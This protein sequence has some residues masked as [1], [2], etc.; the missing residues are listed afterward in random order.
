MKRIGLYLSTLM[1]GVMLSAG[2]T[3]AV[4]VTA[5]P[6]PLRVEIIPD[7]PEPRAVWVPGHWEWSHGA[8]DYYWVEGHWERHPRGRHWESGYWKKRPRGYVW[9]EGHWR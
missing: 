3:G 2:C 8:H 7:R 4:Y 9:I 1:L 5:E 6:P